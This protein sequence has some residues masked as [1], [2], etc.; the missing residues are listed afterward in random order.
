MCVSLHRF[1]V[2]DQFRTSSQH[3]NKEIVDDV[4]SKIIVFASHVDV[5]CVIVGGVLFE[6]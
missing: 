1:G 6:C 4:W 5:I 2:F 3:I